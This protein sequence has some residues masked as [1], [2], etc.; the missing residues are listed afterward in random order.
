MSKVSEGLSQREIA[1]YLK[2]SRTTVA[3]YLHYLHLDGDPTEGQRRYSPSMLDPY[4]AYLYERWSGGCHNG[5]KLWRE[6]KEQGYS[7]S[8]AMV[9]K[10]ACQ[11]RRIVAS[12]EG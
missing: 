9:T 11:Q 10:W 3:R 6:L 2:L 8:H 4:L 12:N 5:T 1:R 7:G